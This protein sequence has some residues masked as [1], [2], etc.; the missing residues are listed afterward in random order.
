MEACQA[1]KPAG[2]MIEACVVRHALVEGMP[3]LICV[4]Q[5]GSRLQTGKC[6]VG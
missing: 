4:D 6:L 2:R 5:T 3:R 1:G